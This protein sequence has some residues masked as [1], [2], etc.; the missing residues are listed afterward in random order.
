MIGGLLRFRNR[1]FVKQAVAS[2]SIALII[3]GALAAVQIYFDMLAEKERIETLGAHHLEPALGTLTLA[4][5]RL[6]ETVAYD[7]AK[8]LL[9]EDAITRVTVRDDFGK[10]LTEVTQAPTHTPVLVFGTLFGSE[11]IVTNRALVLEPGARGVGSVELAVDPLIAS[12]NF[13]YRTVTV[14]LIGVVKSLLLSI[15]LMALFYLTSARRINEL[16]LRYNETFR[17]PRGLQNM[18]EIERL[19]QSLDAW[20]DEKTQLVTRMQ[21]AASAGD[22]GI[23]EYDIDADT[24]SWDGAMHELFGT[25]PT[26]FKGRFADWS[27]RVHPED[28]AGSQERFLTAIETGEVFDDQFRIITPDG[29]EKHVRAKAQIVPLAGGQRGA[30]GVNFD[31]SDRVHR[32][33]QLI[34]ARDAADRA[35]AKMRYAATHDKLTDLPNRRALDLHLQSLSTNS[36]HGSQIAFLQ[37]DLDRFKSINDAFGHTVGDFVLTETGKILKT[38]GTENIFVARFGGDE[39]CVVL[40][41][42]NILASAREVASSI[43]KWCAQSLEYGDTQLHFGASIGIATGTPDQLD[44]LHENADIALYVAKRSEGDAF[45]VFDSEMRQ[46]AERHKRI[47]DGLRVALNEDQIILHFQPK[48]SAHDRELVGLEALVRWHHPTLGI[49]PPVEFLPVAR[50]I[51]LEG[52]IDRR[53]LQLTSETVLRLYEA[54]LPIPQVAVNVGLQRLKDPCLLDDIDALGPFLCQLV[55]EVLETVDL[56]TFHRELGLVL[57]GLRERGVKLEVD[58]FG[59]GHASITSLLS[60]Q[61]DGLK[62]DRSL[63]AG[64]KGMQLPSE[65]FLRA[66]IEIGRAS[67]IKI[68]AEGIETEHQAQLLERLGCD[69]LQGYLFA[70]PMNEVDLINWLKSSRSVQDEKKR[71]QPEA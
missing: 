38:L 19:S 39:F 68:T 66:L 49:V 29:V 20:A 24:L 67:Q 43:I 4:A 32:E 44:K 64:V 51:G 53:V 61:P 25:R 48:V 59:T 47:A 2:V 42:Q 30:I 34:S 22:I 58:D 57:D 27:D 45:A 8:G 16:N 7:V 18:D 40:N 1:L 65:G 35:T 6:D 55:F 28:L 56:D 52:E 9:V 33:A 69:I 15:A 41:G 13:S 10:V 12:R 11:P 21:L 71:L 3:G 62:L 60:L 14:L 46:E 63:V 36:S 23:W 70:K 50:E 26:D 37:I 17:K 31:I 54:S 5:F